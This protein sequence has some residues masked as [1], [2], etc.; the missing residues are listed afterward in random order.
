MRL[1]KAEIEAIINNKKS[2]ILKIPSWRLITL[3]SFLNR[4]SAGFQR[5]K[6]ANTNPEMFK[7][8]AGI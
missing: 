2:P 1:N 4:V 8:A 3:V 6:S 5:V 7:I